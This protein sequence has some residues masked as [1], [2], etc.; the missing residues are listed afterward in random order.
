MKPLQ[1]DT[2]AAESDAKLVYKC[3]LNLFIDCVY[4]TFTNTARFGTF[5]TL[6]LCELDVAA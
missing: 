3:I 5:L 2:D 4:E 1:R 6:V